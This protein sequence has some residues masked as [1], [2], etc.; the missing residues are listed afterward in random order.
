MS[1]VEE[2]MCCAEMTMEEATLS[3]RSSVSNLAAALETKEFSNVS[4]SRLGAL[5]FLLL[6]LPLTHHVLGKTLGKGARLGIGHKVCIGHPFG[7]TQQQV[8]PW[9]GGG[10]RG[11]RQL[12]RPPIGCVSQF[13]E[14]LH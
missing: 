5:I 6:P 2:K 7:V 9:L 1:R 11:R 10:Q 14:G 3:P 4:P 8:L 12:L 13:V